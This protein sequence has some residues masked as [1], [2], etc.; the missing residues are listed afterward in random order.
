MKMSRG[1][2]LL[3]ILLGFITGCASKPSKYA[4]KGYESNPEWSMARNVTEAAGLE[5]V[6]DVSPADA[7]R[8]GSFHRPA[9]AIKEE[10]GAATWLASAVLT[11]FSSISFMTMPGLVAGEGDHRYVSRFFAWMPR[12]Q[13]S[14]PEEAIEK[15]DTMMKEAL[16]MGLEETEFP[17]PYYVKPIPASNAYR[18][19]DIGFTKIRGYG[20]L[21]SGG[22]CDE[23]VYTCR[24]FSGFARR[25]L[26][27]P[28]Q[29]V[30]GKSPDFLGGGDA[31]VFSRLSTF[32]PAPS[33]FIHPDHRRKKVVTPGLPD[34]KVWINTTKH[35]PEWVFLYVPPLGLYDH[36]KKDFNPIP[37]VV[38]QGKVHF[39]VTPQQN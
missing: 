15:L 29:V 19:F 34:L 4:Q 9:P 10:V 22:G 2:L 38:K 35:L 37:A 32:S 33:I 25:T 23:G 14:T 26:E 27:G 6:F 5:D 8:G 30:A 11:D 36:E 18:D 20:H 7:Q 21:I 17:E 24:Y 16:R 13:A 12:D 3:I 31:W 28:G 1:L 39:F